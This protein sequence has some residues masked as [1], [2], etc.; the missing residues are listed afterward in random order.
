MGLSSPE[1]D[2]G[3]LAAARYDEWYSRG[4]GRRAD[5]VGRRLLSDALRAIQPVRS[6]LEVGSGTGHFADLWQET[7]L[8]AVGVDIARDRLRYSRLQRS[9]FPVVLGD[10]TALPFQDASVDIVVLVTALE[11]IV[12]PSRALE[13]AARV[14]RRGIVIGTLNSWSPVAWWRGLR[15][16][17]GRRGRSSYEGAGFFSPLELGK[18]VR[19]AVPVNTRIQWRTGLYPVSWLDR[20]TVLPI[21][22]FTVMTVAFWKEGK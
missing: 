10:A 17:P 7:G 9:E 20:V 22:A 21:G 18:L 16:F 14:A 6:L 13:E 19:A 8:R 11:F 3:L 5:L 12:P 4:F 15:Q 2:P 1:T